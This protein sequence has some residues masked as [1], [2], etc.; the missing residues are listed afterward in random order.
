MPLYLSSNH[1]NV[2]FVTFRFIEVKDAISVDELKISFGI[3]FSG[4]KEA[5]VLLEVNIIVIMKLN[6]S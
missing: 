2:V 4:A 6:K 1:V 3:S 5:D